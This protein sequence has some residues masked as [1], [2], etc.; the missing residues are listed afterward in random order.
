M[1]A[2]PS[3]ILSLDLSPMLI[4]YYV[5]NPKV[6]D[7]EMCKLIVRASLTF[8]IYFSTTFT[9]VILLTNKKGTSYLL[10]LRV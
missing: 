9:L 5:Y 1:I 7:Q 6:E 3:N 10:K 8:S 2:L 4:D